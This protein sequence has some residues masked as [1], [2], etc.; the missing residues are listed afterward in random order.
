MVQ[1]EDKVNSLM[2]NLKLEQLDDANLVL[3]KEYV[4]VMSPLAK[5]FDVLQSEV[6]SYLG[7]V[8]PCI[9]K[10]KEALME[11]KDLATNGYGVNIRRGLLSSIEK[12]YDFSRFNPLFERGSFIIATSVHPRFKRNWIP[13]EDKVLEMNVRKLLRCKLEELKDMDLEVKKI[14]EMISSTFHQECPQC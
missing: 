5:Y 4:A 6:N 3:L 14:P 1:P 13:K 8:I 10:I 11:A 12:R 2:N 9:Q 7:C